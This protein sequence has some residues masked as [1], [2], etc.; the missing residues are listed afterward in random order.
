MKK[1]QGNIA[2]AFLFWVDLAL[3]GSFWPQYFPFKTKIALLFDLND[4]Y[5]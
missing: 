5:Q 2:G 1:L 4:K 3:S